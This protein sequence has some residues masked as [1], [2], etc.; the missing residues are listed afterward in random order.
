MQIKGVDMDKYRAA[1]IGGDAEN[2]AGLRAKLRASGYRLRRAASVPGWP[3]GTEVYVR[4]RDGAVEDKDA[5][6][7]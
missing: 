2:A 3:E 4:K 1:V 6:E 7:G 5:A